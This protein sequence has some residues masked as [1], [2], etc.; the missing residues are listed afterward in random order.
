[1]TVYAVA[2]VRFTDR[3][4]YD[5][6]EAGFMEVFKRHSGR[7]LAADEAPVVVEGKWDKEKL[8]IL[9][10]PDEP[11]FTAW[12]QSPEYREIARDRHMGAET[13]LLLGRGFAGP[14]SRTE[15]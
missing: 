7:V 2:Q 4:A 11:S 10:F 15:A 1:M 9:S 13:L 8:V 12:A 5:R 3:V 14:A 6:Y